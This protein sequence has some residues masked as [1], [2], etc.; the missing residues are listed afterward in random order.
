VFVDEPAALRPG[1]FW[2][3]KDVLPREWQPDLEMSL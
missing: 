1:Y 3:H 2:D